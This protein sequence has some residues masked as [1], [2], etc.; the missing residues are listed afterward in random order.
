MPT[1][2]S[3]CRKKDNP[4][5][6]IG[7]TLL[8]CSVAV[9]EEMANTL[10]KGCKVH[11]IQSYQRVTDKVCKHRHPQKRAVEKEAFNLVASAVIEGANIAAS[12]AAI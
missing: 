3:Y 11:W 7:K 10:L 1:V 5:F 4:E 8:D 6:C 9:G 2:L 12:I